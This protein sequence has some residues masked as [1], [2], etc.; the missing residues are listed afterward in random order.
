[1]FVY[2]CHISYN[3]ENLNFESLLEMDN[4]YD[5]IIHKLPTTHNEETFL[6]D[7]LV[8]LKLCD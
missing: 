6:H 1:M 4:N 5:N 3:K 8:I 7:F 2:T